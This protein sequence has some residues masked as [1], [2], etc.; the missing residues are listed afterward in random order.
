MFDLFLVML[1]LT[2][3]I[4]MIIFIR[5]YFNYRSEINQKLLTLQEKTDAVITMQKKLDILIKRVT[6]LERIVTD[7]KIDL[8][9]EI[10]QL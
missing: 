5:H 7:S 9:H 3:P 8:N 1:A 2:S 4:L 10:S 6:V